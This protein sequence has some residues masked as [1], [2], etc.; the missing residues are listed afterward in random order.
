[1]AQR[2]ILDTGPLLDLLLYQFWKEQGYS[3]D[4]NRLQCRKQFNVSPEQI[5]R[6]LGVQQSILV[7]P[8]VF[9]EMGR[10]ARDAIGRVPNRAKGGSLASFWGIATRELRQMRIDEKWTTFLS[11]EQNAIEEVGPTDAAL[12]RCAQDTGEERVPILTHDEALRGRCH[13]QQIRCLL[14]SEILGQLYR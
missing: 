1:V 4:E 13:K 11:L 3:I 6:F 2:I 9:V 10:L 5:S 12:M 14:T 7:V 8:G